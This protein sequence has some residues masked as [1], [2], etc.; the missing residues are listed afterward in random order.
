[1]ENPMP[2]DPKADLV[3]WAVEWRSKNTLDGTSR[4]LIWED[5]LRLFRTRRECRAFIHGKY[6]YIRDRDDLRAEPHG[7]HIPRA[8]RAEV[9]RIER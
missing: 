3:A 6:G 4:H 1:M 9:R 2:S 5:G 7:W 8:V